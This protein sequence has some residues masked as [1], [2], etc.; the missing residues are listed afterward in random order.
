M[1]ER[2]VAR[3]VRGR[4]TMDGAGVRLTRVFGFGD[5]AS[6]DPFLLLDAFG[7]DKTEEYI[8]GFPWHPHRGIE[9]VTYL[10]EGR[11]RHGDSMG[12]S[13]EIG[14]GDL[15]W[16]TAG[17]GIIHEEMP[18]ASPRGVHGFQLWVNLPKDEKMSDPAYRGVLAAE[19]PHVGVEGGEVLVIAGSFGGVAGPIT[20]IARSPTYLDLHLDSGA[21]L[22]LEAP[23]GETAFLYVYDGSLSSGGAEEAGS[24]SG[25]LF[26]EGGS[27]ALAAGALGA[28]GIFFRA[29]PLGESV[30]WRGPIVMNTEAELDEAFEEIR[31]G[32][33]V[34]KRGTERN[35][36]F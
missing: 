12:N 7:S 16:M 24:G 25:L 34:K 8:A 2:E 27:I 1:A 29:R 3:I 21:R 35:S 19:V 15:Q 23:A 10:L 13:G 36:A 14:P 6:F 22:E 17:S 9:T 11:V 26:G 31:L 5:T 20:G 4:R 18:Q 32:S 28:R 30:A 33:F